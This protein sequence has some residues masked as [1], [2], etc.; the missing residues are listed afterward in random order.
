M[1]NRIG[2]RRR[3]R[4]HIFGEEAVYGRKIYCQ[5]REWLAWMKKRM[6]KDD[7]IDIKR[8]T[9]SEIQMEAKCA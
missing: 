7:R 3:R 6:R 2:K 1:D 4:L 5:S 8:E 9:S